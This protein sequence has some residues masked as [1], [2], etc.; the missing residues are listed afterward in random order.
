MSVE[1]KVNQITKPLILS[2]SSKSDPKWKFAA[3]S[4]LN[5]IEH[6]S[7]VEDIIMNY[8]VEIID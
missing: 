2:F 8:S 7:I 6:F 4:V 3:F 1:I 5:K